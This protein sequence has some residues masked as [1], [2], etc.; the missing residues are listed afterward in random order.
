MLSARSITKAANGTPFAQKTRHI[1]RNCCRGEKNIPC[2]KFQ[3]HKTHI[4]TRLALHPRILHT[5]KHTHTRSRQEVARWEKSE[6]SQAAASHS[7]ERRGAARR[8][9]LNALSFACSLVLFFFVSLAPSINCKRACV[10]TLVNLDWWFWKVLCFFL[11]FFTQVRWIYFFFF[12]GIFVCKWYC[13]WEMSHLISKIIAGNKRIKR[14]RA[15]NKCANDND[16]E[17]C[18][19][20]ITL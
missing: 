17:M 16:R 10:L 20:N 4:A 7:I 8:C 2:I 18:Q 3:S 13:R 6:S 5:H 15:R 1:G 12:Y 11:N 14:E 19:S 9:S